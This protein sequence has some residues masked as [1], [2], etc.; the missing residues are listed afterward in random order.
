M[1]DLVALVVT[2]AQTR[3]QTRAPTPRGVWVE[4]SRLSVVSRCLDD[5]PFHKNND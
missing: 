4:D 3:A 2:L 5:T 1:E